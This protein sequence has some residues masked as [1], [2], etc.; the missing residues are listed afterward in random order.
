MKSAGLKISA[1]LVVAVMAMPLLNGA[2]TTAPATQPTTGPTTN[3]S[4]TITWDQAIKHV[5]ETVT[6]T[7]PVVGTHIVGD[8]KN[9]VLNVGK[10]YPDAGRLTIF[11]PY[12]DK[13]GSP[14]DVYKGKTVTV[15]GKVVL[16]RK[17]AEIKA[18][19]KDVVISKP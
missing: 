9:M 15:T 8:K 11:L 7:G 16:F 4:V 19:V 10:D 3:P 2:T 12:D 14:D 13:A 18:D 5:G 17:T 1:G 6:A